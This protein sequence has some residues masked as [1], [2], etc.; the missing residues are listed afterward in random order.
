MTFGVILTITNPFSSGYLSYLA[1]VSAW[2]KIADK[3]LILDGGSNDESIEVL[4][5]KIGTCPSVEVIKNEIVH[6][7]K[8]DNFN[9]SQLAVNLNYGL[10]LINTDWAFAFSTDYIPYKWDR[11]KLEDEL[12][13]YEN[14]YWV[15]TYVGKPVNNKIIHRYNQRNVIFNLKKIKNDKLNIGF[16]INKSN[17]I[18][19]DFPIIFEE[20]SSF[21]DPINRFE[22]TIYKGSILKADSTINLECIAYGHFFYN[23]EQLEYK[24]QRWDRAFSRFIGIA[25]ARLKQLL[26][27]HNVPRGKKYY[28]KEEVLMWDHP[29]EIKEVI[30]E[31]FT[32]GMIGGII[33]ERTWLDKKF[34]KIILSLLKIERKIRTIYMKIFKGLR[35]EKDDL[36]WEK[37]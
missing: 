9:V 1:A 25:P 10:S 7:G 28:S 4:F 13:K 12:K 18:G 16:G 26:I 20:K 21:I 29:E 24:V 33:D 36:K 14:E 8:N 32:E 15:K 31:Y 6:W 22:K 3:V 17:N 23:K 34:E 35:A 19:S 37:I 27:W 2:I 5:Q 11:K 30:E